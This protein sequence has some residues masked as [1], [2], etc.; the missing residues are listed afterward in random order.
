MS[1]QAAPMDMKEFFLKEKDMTLNGR[2]VGKVRK[3]GRKK[4]ESKYNHSTH[5]TCVKFSRNI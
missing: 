1:M 3:S 5:Y 2:Y 4:G